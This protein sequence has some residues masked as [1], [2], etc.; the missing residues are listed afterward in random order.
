MQYW[1][2]YLFLTPYLHFPTC[3]S[4]IGEDSF[5]GA[6]ERIKGSCSWCKCFWTGMTSFWL[7]TP[8]KLRMCRTNPKE[9]WYNHKLLL[10]NKK[11]DYDMT[12]EFQIWPSILSIF[13][14]NSIYTNWQV[15]IVTLPLSLSTNSKSKISLRCKIVFIIQYPNWFNQ[16]VFLV[17]GI[18]EVDGSP[19][20]LYILYIKEGISKLE[21]L[22]SPAF[23]K[24]S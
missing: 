19:I 24:K 13:S 23:W 21:W 6:S 10:F 11:T 15:I 14:T 2:C 7:S 4:F 17:V 22:L 20:Q 1:F 9:W 12:Y 3:P 16:H 5:K 8:Q 18:S